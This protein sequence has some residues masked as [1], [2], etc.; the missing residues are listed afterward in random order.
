MDKPIENPPA[1]RRSRIVVLD[2]YTLNPGDL[3]WSPL[4]ILGETQIYPRSSAEEVIP[5]ALG[6]PFVLTN[7]TIINGH[8]M[9]AL[10]GLRYIGVLATGYNVVDVEAAGR[11]GIVVTNIPSYGTMSVAQMV[12]AL[13]LNITN[14][15]QHHADRVRAGAWSAC[16]D[17]CFWDMPLCELDTLTMGIVGLGRIGRA[18]ARIAESFGMKV[19]AAERTKYADISPG[20]E[21]TDLDSI[22]SRSDVVSLHCPLT[23][24]TKE[25]VNAR[26]L[27]LMKP[28]AILINTSRGALIREADLANAL[29]GGRI[30][31]AALD[32]LSIEPPPAGNPLLS[33]KNCLVTPHQAWGTRAARQRLLDMAVENL[34]NFQQGRPQNVVN[35][36][37]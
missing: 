21:L 8:T 31:G 37:V 13:L 33:A 10:P 6:A 2:G 1:N 11:R 35:G 29:N 25:L 30:A 34:A 12:F 27:A 18:V 16:P 24:E 14:H 15:V 22:F 20:I 32:V 19:I 23:A 5:R 7:K 3:D 17:F 9:E 4:E 26:R 28:S 36:S